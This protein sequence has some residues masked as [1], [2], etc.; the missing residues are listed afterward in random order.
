MKKYYAHSKDSSDK[1]AWQLLE[2]HLCN[3]AAMAGDFAKVFGGKDWGFCGGML[4]DAGKA[5]DGFQ[6]RLEG[7]GIRVDHS[8]FGA[9]LAAENCGRLGVLLAYAIAGHHGGLPDGGEQTGQLYYRLYHTKLQA[10]LQELR[11]PQCCRKIAPPFLLARESAGFSLSFF[12]RMIFSCLVDADFLDTEHFCSP[13]KAKFRPDRTDAGQIAE[14]LSVFQAHMKTVIKKAEKSDVN[15]LRR[16]V[17]EQCVCKA[18][19]PRQIFSLTVPTGGGKTYSSM[20][21]ALNHA[22]QNKL[23]R[24]IYAIPFTSIIEQ[25]AAVFKKIFGFE[26]VLE[27]HCNFMEKEDDE[28]RAYNRRNRLATENWDLPI[29]VTTNVQFFESLFAHKTSKCRKLHNIAGSVIILDEAQ[30]IPTG[31]LRP[32]LAVLKELVKNYGCSVVLCTATQPALDDSNSL[33]KE[34]LPEIQE[35][36]SEPQKL[37]T[38]LERTKIVFIGKKTDCE[39]AGLLDQEQQAL[40]IVSTKPQARSVFEQLSRKAGSYHLSTNMYPLHRQRILQE[41]RDRLDA[42]KSCRVVS[43]SLVEAGVD[44]DFPVVYRAMAGLDSIAQAAGRCNREGKLNRQGKLGRVFVFESETMPSMPWLKRCISRSQEALRSLPKAN[45]VGVEIMKRY[46]ELLYDAENLDFKEIMR[47]LN[48]T[49]LDRDLS[50]PFREVSEQFRFIEE[51]SK[52]VIIVSEPKTEKLVR[53]LRYLD[54]TR[55][56]LRALQPY[57]VQVRRQDI[58]ILHR[59]GSIELVN[60]DIPVLLNKNAYDNDLGLCVDKA[61][62]WDVNQLQL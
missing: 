39:L 4:H 35:I 17:F 44:L 23:R 53:E 18:S 30:A 14:L 43:T 40:C 36:V 31:Y 51:D 59:G 19:L 34:A 54:Y 50:F 29:V 11:I 20:A 3:V 48:P 15:R 8:T 52:G 26:N 37:F 41:I 25:N 10:P 16:D 5:T 62:I 42:G 32:C 55:L 24:I 21:F 38:E 57:T 45:P 56:T 13:E 61:G 2:E 49:Q 12:T 33:R 1:K 46:F 27:H 47:L 7:S 60:N 6:K 58:D 28:N 9:R 22:V